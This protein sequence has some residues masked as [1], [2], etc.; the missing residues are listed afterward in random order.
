LQALV[1]QAVADLTDES[2]SAPTMKQMGQ[3]IKRVTQQAAGRAEG[4]R[5]A[6]LVKATLK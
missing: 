5:V 2:G 4:R 1:G 3:V 6:A